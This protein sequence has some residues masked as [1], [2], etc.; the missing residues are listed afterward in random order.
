MAGLY[1]H[2][3]FCREACYYCNFHFSTSK[4]LRQAYVDA[5][6][7]EISIKKEKIKQMPSEA[8]FDKGFQTIY[9]GGGTPSQLP[10]DDLARIAD[11]LRNN[12]EQ[13]GD[14]EFT[15]EANPDDISANVLRAWQAMGVNRLSIGIQ[16]F[17]ENDLQYLG[18]R[19]DAVQAEYAIKSAQD[20]GFDNINIDLIYGIPTQSEKDWE[21]NLGVF[22]SLNIPHLSAYCLTVEPKT[23]LHVL[24]EKGKKDKVSETQAVSH[25]EILIK[26]ARENGLTHYEISNFCRGDN[27]SKHNLSYWQQKPYL[28]FGAAAHSFYAD[29]RTWNMAHTAGFIKNIAEGKPFCE[30]EHLDLKTK[31]NEYILTSLRTLW[32]CD[33]AYITNHFG[34]SY[35][36][37]LTRQSEKY[38]TQ[39][40]LKK[41]NN[42]LYLTDKGKL[43]ADGIAADLFMVD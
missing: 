24:I 26:F 1:V 22:Y 6:I 31:Y 18:R 41:V 10:P 17:K 2:I 38:I 36:D 29:T 27:F 39:G 40:L 9:F 11:A 35:S 28:G 4:K 14:P 33:C 25:F 19:H 16:S 37:Y 3:P 32:G 13:D 21:E 23:P 34:K 12:F 8:G 30:E 15:L 43:L 5:L 7:K 20:M 42:S